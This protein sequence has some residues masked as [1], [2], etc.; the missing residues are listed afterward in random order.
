[1][2]DSVS[3]KRMK[4]GYE[5]SID[6]YLDPPALYCPPGNAALEDAT[7]GSADA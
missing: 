5:P 4:S 7:R 2:E 3:S 1:M 6:A